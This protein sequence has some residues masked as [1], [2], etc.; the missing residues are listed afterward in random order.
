MAKEKSTKIAKALAYLQ[1]NPD[2]TAYAA[3]KHA[4]LPPTTVYAA[5]KRSRALA[6]G[7]CPACG[8]ATSIILADGLISGGGGGTIY[9]Q[10]NGG[11]GAGVGNLFNRPK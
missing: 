4:H 9:P 7:R 10:T 2:A 11:G 8:G 1:A 5:L 6:A 3:A